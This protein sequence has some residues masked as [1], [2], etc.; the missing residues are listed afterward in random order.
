NGTLD[1][2]QRM[3]VSP[4]AWSPLAS[5]R[6]FTD[7]DSAQVRRIVSAAEPILEKYDA[8]LDQI[9]LAWLLRHPSKILPVLGTARPER[10]EAAVDA[11]RIELTREEW[12]ML[13]EASLGHE[14]P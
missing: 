10:V 6:I 4:M 14:I 13:W 9:L 3:K 12:F 5:G 2:C 1:L 8:E 11:L 7:L